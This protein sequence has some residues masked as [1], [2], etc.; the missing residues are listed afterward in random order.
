MLSWIRNSSTITCLLLYILKLFLLLWQTFNC[1]KY[2]FKSRF[3]YLSFLNGKNKSRSNPK[4][5]SHLQNFCYLNICHNRRNSFCSS[6][7]L[8]KIHILIQSSCKLEGTPKFVL[9]RPPLCIGSLQPLDLV[10]SAFL[11]SSLISLFIVWLYQIF[12]QIILFP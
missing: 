2:S 10:Y 3:S 1:K 11:H 6:S 5:L 12:I 4:I 7:W 8:R 9:S